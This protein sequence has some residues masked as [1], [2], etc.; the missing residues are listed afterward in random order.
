M[1]EPTQTLL[2]RDP[3]PPLMPSGVFDPN[4]TPDIDALAENERVKIGLHLLN[5][6]LPR[7]H[8]LAQKGEGDPTA[9]F[10]HAI[11]H[12]REGDWSNAKYWLRRAQAHPILAEI[13]GG[14]PN[15][16]AAFVDQC[17]ATG[18]GRDAK[19]ETAQREEMARLLAW[20][21]SS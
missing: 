3:A 2:A 6:D 11:I 13:Y 17:R 9:D 12:R 19:L 20:A 7:A 18:N 5:D 4:L 15:A 1:T 21:Q 16:P 10:W 8:A 14:D